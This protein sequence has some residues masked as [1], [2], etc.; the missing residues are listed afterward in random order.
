MS[1]PNNTTAAAGARLDQIS[2]KMRDQSPDVLVTHADLELMI[3][4]ALIGS[5]A[6]VLAVAEIS[7]MPEHSQDSA[8]Q[9]LNETIRGTIDE[10]GIDDMVLVA[11]L[12]RHVIHDR[13]ESPDALR[14]AVTTTKGEG[15]E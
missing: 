5:R 4:C 8:K 2:A 7:G 9:A 6:M 14:Y 15:A 10:I 11:A 3:E 13:Y 1:D 12:V